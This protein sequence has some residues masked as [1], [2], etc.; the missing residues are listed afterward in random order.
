M[1]KITPRTRS[2]IARIAACEPKKALFAFTSIN[3]RSAALIAPRVDCVIEMPA[4][5]ALMSTSSQAAGSAI[6]AA[7][8]TT[9]DASQSTCRAMSAGVMLIA[10]TTRTQMLAVRHEVGK[11]R[12]KGV[13]QFIRHPLQ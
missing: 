10:L 5:H 13:V 1:F 8:S 12:K 11:G 6:M 7:I 4:L 9:Y 2:T 3:L